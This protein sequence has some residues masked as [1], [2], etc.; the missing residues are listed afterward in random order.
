MYPFL[1][2]FLDAC[3]L[4]TG[5]PSSTHL[6]ERERERESFFSSSFHRSER[7]EMYTDPDIKR[8]IATTHVHLFFVA[9]VSY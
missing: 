3:L 7:K 1:I 8:R 5:M 6:Q 2:R 9:I 4:D